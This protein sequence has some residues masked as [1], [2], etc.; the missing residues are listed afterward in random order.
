VIYV[1]FTD[2]WELWGDGSGDP[3]QIQFQPMREL[4]RIFN[5]HG[6]RASFY[7]EIMQQL[8]F[9]R[10][11]DRHSELKVLADRWDAAALETFRQGHDIQM[12][13]HPQWS[14]ATY[15]GGRWQLSGS[16][17]LLNHDPIGVKRMLSEGKSY[18]EN[19]LRGVDQNYRC[20]AFRAGHW[21]IAPSPFALSTLAGLGFTLDSS[22]VGGIRYRTSRAQLDYRNVEESFSPYYP[23]MED[24]RKVSTR[25]EPIV[26]VPTHHVEGQRF[27]YLRRDIKLAWQSII[28]DNRAL[29]SRNRTTDETTPSLLRTGK[30]M[31]ERYLIG[32]THISDISH[33]DYPLL[34]Q[35]MNDIRRQARKRGTRHAVAVL[36]GHSKDIRNF[37]DIDCFLRDIKRADDF[38][39]VTLTQLAGKLA[40][41]SVPVR[42]AN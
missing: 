17:S 11:Q 13:L 36:A 24:A 26:C 22:I 23:S 18:L 29:P 14:N 19:L 41:G 9:R 38:C 10:F 21:C 32:E 40:D 39:C 31:V 30:K 20:L 33:L 8:S 3:E 5:R 2:D 1:V 28:K 6:L 16:W 27:Q 35:V 15:A 25:P 42:C 34:R 7:V 12:H 37:A 4:V